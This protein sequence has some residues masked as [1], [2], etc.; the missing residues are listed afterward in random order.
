[1][2]TYTADT[3]VDFAGA[4]AKYVKLTIGGNWGGLAQQAGLS[5]VRFYQIP[6]FARYPSPAAALRALPRTCR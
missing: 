2:P 5:E 4:A 3:T 1:M 6:A